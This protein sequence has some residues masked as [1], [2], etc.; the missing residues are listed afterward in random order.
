[1]KQKSKFQERMLFR[2]IV[3]TIKKK[4]NNI[5]PNNTNNNNPIAN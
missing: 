2:E 5:N 4:D 1:M 3:Y